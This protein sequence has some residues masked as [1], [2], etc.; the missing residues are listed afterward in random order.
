MLVSSLEETIAPSL[1]AAWFA[2]GP[3]SASLRDRIRAVNCSVAGIQLAVLESRLDSSFYGQHRKRIVGEMKRAFEDAKKDVLET[4]PD[5]T[6]V[7]TPAGGYSPWIEL[8]L[9]LSSQ[10]LFRGARE[11]GISIAPGHIHRSNNPPFGH[12][13]GDPTRPPSG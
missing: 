10:A 12:L 11:K 2:A 9:G 3:N 4:F 6:K 13:S 1:K 5:C 8:P 7:N